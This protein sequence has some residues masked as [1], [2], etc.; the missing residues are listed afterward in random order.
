MTTKYTDLRRPRVNRDG[1][2]TAEVALLGLNGFVVLAAAELAGEVELLVETTDVIT[3]C[4]R[5]GVVAEPHG[6]RPVSVR[7]LPLAGRPTVLVWSKR[8]WR[9]LQP[10]CAQRS[11]SEASEATGP[12]RFSPSGPGPGGCAGSA[13]TARRSPPSPGSSGSAGTP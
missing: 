9:C 6:R 2:R 4:P 13:R 11:W 1:S 7:D 3:G 12:R 5:C 8:L 10:W